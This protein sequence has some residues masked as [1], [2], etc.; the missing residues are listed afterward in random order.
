MHTVVF[1]DEEGKSVRP[2]LMWNDTRTAEMVPLM[3]EKIKKIT[4]ADIA[5]DLGDWELG[6]LYRTNDPALGG[7]PW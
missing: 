2:A 1:L 7:W 5:E 4:Y 3:K 6:D